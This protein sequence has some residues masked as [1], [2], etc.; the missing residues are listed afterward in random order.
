MPPSKREPPPPLL[1]PTR[2]ETLGGDAEELTLGDIRDRKRTVQF[3][4]PESL[5]QLTI[6]HNDA[7]ANELASKVDGGLLTVDEAIDFFGWAARAREAGKPFTVQ[8]LDRWAMIR[9]RTGL[10]LRYIA[11]GKA[12]VEKEDSDA[13]GVQPAGKV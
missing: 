13:G 7:T 2:Q 8:D 5:M 10:P 9:P 6:T 12:L 3:M 11:S 1:P 4:I